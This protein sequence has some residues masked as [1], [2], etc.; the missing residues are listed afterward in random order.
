MY[1][2]WAKTLARIFAPGVDAQVSKG[3]SLI[4]SPG[5]GKA[6]HTETADLWI[7]AL[8]RQEFLLVNIGG[9]HRSTNVLTQQVPQ[10][11]L[12]RHLAA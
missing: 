5:L 12:V 6:R 10:E 9:E 11:A 3:I 8:E 1:I 2:A 7:Q 4:Y